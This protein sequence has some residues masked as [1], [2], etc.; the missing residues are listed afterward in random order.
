[1]AS[2]FQK[3]LKTVT[4]NLG[5]AIA[6]RWATARSISLDEDFPRPLVVGYL[7]FDFPINEDGTLGTPI[8]TQCQ[9]EARSGPSKKTG[10]RI[11][12]IEYSY[13]LPELRARI[14]RWLA[15]DRAT[16]N[17][18]LMAW[19]EGRGITTPAGAWVRTET[20]PEDITDA[21]G[22]LDIPE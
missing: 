11:T 3:A 2:S 20:S 22:E 16:N 4:D 6:L 19:L 5:G 17:A 12:T 15:Q 7:G 21:I 9:L 14:T 8:A 10:E 18:K 13:T 1:M